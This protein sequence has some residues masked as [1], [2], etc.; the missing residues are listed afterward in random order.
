[1]AP[2]ECTDDGACRFDKFSTSLSIGLDGGGGAGSDTWDKESASVC[3]ASDES[4]K[5]SADSTQN[6]VPVSPVTATKP[7]E[8][9]ASTTKKDEEDVVST[10]KRKMASVRMRKTSDQ[11]VRKFRYL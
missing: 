2:V 11:T 3:V 9:G 10:L 4:R 7:Q 5:S 1:M 8:K 6:L